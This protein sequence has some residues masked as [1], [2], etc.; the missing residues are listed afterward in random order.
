M[1]SGEEHGN[2][3]RTGPVCAADSNAQGQPGRDGRQ[4]ALGLLGK[5]AVQEPLSELGVSY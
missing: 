2:G 4:L 3:A 5:T 1:L